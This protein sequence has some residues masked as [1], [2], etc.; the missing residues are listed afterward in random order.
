L[1]QPLAQLAVLSHSPQVLNRKH[2]QHLQYFLHLLA[3]VA[4]FH[5]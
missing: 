4:G 1:L 2:M 3:V 5:G